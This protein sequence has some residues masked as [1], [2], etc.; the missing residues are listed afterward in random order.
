VARV[1]FDG[2][3]NAEEEI[4]PDPLSAPIAQSWRSGAAEALELQIAA[5]HDT[6]PVAASAT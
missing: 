4:F 2:V 3:E 5:L 1:I 6:A